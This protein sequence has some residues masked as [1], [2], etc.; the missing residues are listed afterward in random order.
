MVVLTLF[1]ARL[2][3]EMRIALFP[4]ESTAL[5]LG[6][7]GALAGLI[8]T[9]YVTTRPARAAT[10]A[11]REMPAE[12][13]VTIIIGL[14][15]GLV[16][17]A[18][19]AV[20]LSLLPPPFGQWAPS[21]VATVAAYISIT[22]FAYRADDVIDLATRL[23]RRSEPRSQS[24][25]RSGNTGPLGTPSHRATSE[26][27]PLSE[28]KVLLDSSAI[29]DGRILDISRTGFLYG[30]LIVPTFILRELQHIAD[31]S[32]PQRRSRGRRGLEILQT[33]QTESKVPVTILDIEVDGAREADAKLVALA[34]QIDALL[35]TTDANLR[36]TANI[37]GVSVL[38]V[39]DLANAVKMVF[40]PGEVL[41]LHII[42]EGR[43][44]N[45]GVGYL[46]DGTM[47]VVEDGRRYI[48][49]TID[50]Q[51]TKAHQTANGKM[52]FARPD[53]NSRK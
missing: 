3:I 27:R 42:A 46:G 50:V 13:L 53:E 38:N 12:A 20:P 28:I 45:Q 8:L 41:P 43:E 5:L 44:A 4:P 15:F 16:V 49:R 6:L 11:I 30:Q 36:R 25:S 34:K 29:I 37:Q 31:E 1:G 9:P 52:Y 24:G 39:N 35:L 19:F 33:L 47:V 7:V 18:L 23:F 2:G 26:L 51:V 17:A 10:R 40:L 22:I 21:V 32:N 48:D 14:I